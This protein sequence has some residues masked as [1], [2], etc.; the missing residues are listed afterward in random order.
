MKK[1]EHQNNENLTNEMNIIYINIHANTSV[2]FTKKIISKPSVELCLRPNTNPATIK[3]RTFE[4][5]K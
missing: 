1:K 3:A 4:V 5:K 2:K